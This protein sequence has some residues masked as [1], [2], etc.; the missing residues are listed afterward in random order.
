[1]RQKRLLAIL[2]CVTMMAA[3]APTSALQIF[4]NNYSRN[5]V[6][7]E[8]SNPT[9]VETVDLQL[10]GT[11]TNG[12]FGIWVKPDSGQTIVGTA[13]VIDGDTIEIHG[14]RI[15]LHGI[16]TPESS[17]LCERDGKSYRCGQ[18]AALALSD[19]ISQRKATGAGSTRSFS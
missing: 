4:L 8:G 19:R 18:V 7:V 2:A 17:Q 3:A 5:G 12:T 16:D 15:R 9:H 6:I 10:T 14:Q 1:M 13:S 11:D